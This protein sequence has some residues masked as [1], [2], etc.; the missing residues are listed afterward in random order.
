LSRSSIPL[1]RTLGV[2]GLLSWLSLIVFF[3][4]GGPFGAFSD[5]GN[6]ALGLLSGLWP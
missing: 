5:V 3:I 6:G 1:A 2:V 4:V